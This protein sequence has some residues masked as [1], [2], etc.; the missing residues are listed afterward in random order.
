MTN[1]FAALGNGSTTK[2]RPSFADLLGN[3]KRAVSAANDAGKVKDT[4]AEQNKAEEPEPVV[5][6]VTEP[7]EAHKKVMAILAEYKYIE[8]D[9]P[10]GHDYWRLKTEA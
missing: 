7:N 2:P 9:I 3:L 4:P 6:P 1:P 10:H 5:V 8:S